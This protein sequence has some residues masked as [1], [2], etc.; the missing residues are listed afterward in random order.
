MTGAKADVA[1]QR[2]QKI[3][4]SRVAAAAAILAFAALSLTCAVLSQGFV[5]ADA[6]T[7]Y[8][9]AKWAFADPVNL[10][11][12]WARPFGTALFA[13]PAHWGGRLGVRVTSLLVAIGCAW[14]AQGIARDQGVR[15]PVLALLFTLGQPLLFV[16]SFAEMTELPF[17]LLLGG[18][19]W[20][21][22]R[23][24]WFWMAVLAGLT[25][26]ARPEGFGF[27]L[28][29]AAALVVYRRWWWIAILLLPLVGWDIGG[30]VVTQR[31]GAWW[32][33]LAHAWPWS[34]EGM[35]GRGN[36]LTFVAA[37][38]VVVSPLVLPAAL[39]GVWRSLRW[40]PIEG[41]RVQ[42]RHLRT[43]RLLTG[44]IPL[45][46]LAVHSLL[47]WTGKLG[48][49]GEPR[50]LLI[51]SPFWGVLSA[52]GWE[53][54]FDRF[55]WARPLG[56]AGAAV[57]FPALVNLIHPAVPIPLEG[58]WNTAQ[59]FAHWYRYDSGEFRARYPNVVSS[60]PGVFYFLDENPTGAARRGG[61]TRGVIE[62][63]PPGTVLLWDP[64]YSAHNANVE[65]TTTVGAIVRAGW[66]ED[67][68][69]D[70][71]LNEPPDA[72]GNPDPSKLWH[73]F[74]SR[75]AR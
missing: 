67:R 63:P 47:R 44:L 70:A 3:D 18:A 62:A 16:Y 41:H 59:R 28:L 17:A 23:R 29:A 13:L 5:A 75:Q 66:I 4:S 74:V 55:G 11:D 50:Y 39:I 61:F 65:D 2:R 35:Y 33:W 73:A 27:V 53:W 24:R 15:R 9:Y 12:V 45:F 10:V 14:V 68:A 36:L 46:V 32:A 49:F 51:V 30:W 69:L 60:H 37:L 31:P 8:L 19:F 40:E 20:A 48:S 6:C 34:R 25:P 56:L 21:F 52:Q 26:T 1:I 43:C 22:Q 72:T 58:D 42:E 64:V 71:A 7:H 57:L 38:P 54:W